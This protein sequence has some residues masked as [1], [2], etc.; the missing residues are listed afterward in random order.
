MGRISSD[1]GFLCAPS[2]TTFLRTLTKPREYHFATRLAPRNKV[3]GLI[4]AVE[5]ETSSRKRRPQHKTHRGHLHAC[6]VENPSVPVHRRPEVGF[7]PASG[8]ASGRITPLTAVPYLICPRASYRASEGS[9]STGYIGGWLMS[10][11]AGGYSTRQRPCE[12]RSPFSKKACLKDNVSLFSNPLSPA[13]DTM[14][15]HSATLVEI[16]TAST[17]REQ[18]RDCGLCCHAVGIHLI[19]CRAVDVGRDR[20]SKRRSPELPADSEC[21]GNVDKGG[22]CKHA[23][24]S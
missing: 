11:V 19:H 6:L 17:T 7:A 24:S 5:T 2:N 23:K 10:I 15:I 12:T 18:E 9:E 22:E 14:L 16:S 4:N 20:S 3:K 13:R 1:R 21:H 8:P